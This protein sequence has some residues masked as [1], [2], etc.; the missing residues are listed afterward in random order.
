[1]AK[2]FNDRGDLDRLRQ[3]VE[4][5]RSKMPQGVAK[6]HEHSARH[7]AELLASDL[8]GCFYCG[9]TFTA[10]EIVDWTDGEQTALCPRCGIDSVIGS[11][12]GFP[13]T[14]EFLDGM[15]KYWF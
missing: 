2:F 11:A 10:T 4:V 8:C 12:A 13:L 1:M 5:A 7:R 9:A 6:A 14:K 3:H 15:N